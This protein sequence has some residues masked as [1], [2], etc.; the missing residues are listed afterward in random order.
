VH[1]RSGTKT[2]ERRGF[3]SSSVIP[4]SE[5]QEEGYR[6]DRGGERREEEGEEGARGEE[7]EVMMREIE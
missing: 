7:T 6:G 4:R 3:K 5:E 1:S 2:A